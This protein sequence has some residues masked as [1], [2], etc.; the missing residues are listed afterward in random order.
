VPSVLERGGPAIE[1]VDLRKTYRGGKNAL[2]GVSFAVA[3]GEIF[4]FL[5]PN[6]SGKTTTVRILVTLLRPSA[7]LARVCSLDVAREPGRVRSLVGWAGQ[8]I[9]IDDDLTGVENLAVQ[10]M[11]HGLAHDDAWRRAGELL[12]ELSLDRI[13]TIRT[14]RLS[15]GLRRRLDLATAMVHRPAVLFLDEPTTGLDPPSRAAI[16][17]R[18][19]RMSSEDGVSIFLTTQYL[20]EADRACDRVAI[21]DDGRLITVGTPATLKDEL[22]EDRVAL[23]VA[24][25]DHGAAVQ[26]LRT[27][28]AVTR[29]EP[30]DP[31]LVHVR[32]A[33]ASVAPLIKLLDDAGIGV[34]SIEQRQ[35]TLDD[36][37]VRHTGHSARVEATILG[38]TSGIFASAHGRRRT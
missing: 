16:W 2:A 1:A 28:S 27:S 14:R 3:P 37:F 7:G 17:R 23:S 32:V 18:L 8:S 34:L 24:E 38:A 29:V 6:G 5:G 4:G 20:E 36:V 35:P 13:A 33:A 12:D 26:V 21:I 9:G 22:G 11:L 15:G 30:G 31:I 10:G 19:R 25:V